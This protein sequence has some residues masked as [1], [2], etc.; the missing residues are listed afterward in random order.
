VLLFI[1]AYNCEHQL[2]RVLDA[3]AKEAAVFH[4]V[5][6]VDNGSTD[7]SVQAAMKAASQ[8]PT[9]FTLVQNRLNLNLGGSH[10]V[11]FR[12]AI[13]NGFDF[14]VVLHGDDQADVMDVLPLLETIQVE[15]A[16]DCWLGSRFM[17]GSRLNGY[18]P[19]RTVGNWF[20]NCLFSFVTCRWISDLGSG[21][22]VY[23]VRSLASANWTGFKNNLTFN[24]FLTLAYAH[25]RWN[26]TF[27]PITW[28]EADQVSNVRAF[29]QVIEMLA[30]LF[31]YIFNKSWI[32]TQNHA[33][34]GP[35]C[36]EAN[37]TFRHSKSNLDQCEDTVL[38]H[39]P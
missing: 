22:N 33:D 11:A 9:T 26:C 3:V 18:S 10:K 14:L 5:L 27:F 39:L 37:V 6:I 1:P 16:T 21:L 2:Q 30:L 36:Y 24:Y 7:G 35:D 25:W 4:E 8:I 13:E 19:I 15:T 31:H 23:S 32:F 38:G 34:V 17:R 20:F 29:R 12:Y 28:R